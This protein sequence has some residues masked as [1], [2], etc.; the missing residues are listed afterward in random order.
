VRVCRWGRGSFPARRG[1][2]VCGHAEVG[3][4]N[5]AFWALGHTALPLLC[6][7]GGGPHHGPPPGQ[8]R[9]SGVRGH[10]WASRRAPC[11]LWLRGEQ[12]PGLVWDGGVWYQGGCTW[13]V[14]TQTGFLS[15]KDGGTQGLF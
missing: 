15:V 4:G 11:V 10:G 13:V 5:P 8:T 12:A 1:R 9:L 3:G 14:R 7:G 6:G 2:E